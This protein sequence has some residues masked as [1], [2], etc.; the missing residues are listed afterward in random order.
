[1]LRRELARRRREGEAFASA[2]RPAKDLALR[3]A[4]SQ[5]DRESW[6]SVL[7]D[8]KLAFADAFARSGRTFPAL[9]T[10]FGDR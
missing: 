3:L 7:E 4:T 9:E 2:W 8:C 1:V 5:R 10:L 6:N